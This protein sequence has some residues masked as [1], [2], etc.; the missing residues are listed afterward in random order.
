MAVHIEESGLE[1][2]LTLQ[3]DH[4]CYQMKVDENGYL[5]HLYYGPPV[6]GQDMS[7]R[8]RR[9][10]RSFSPNPPGVGAAQDLSLDWLPQEYPGSGTGDF[11][12]TALQAEVP[13]YTGC[14]LRFARMK[15]E[16]GMFSLSGLP[17]VYAHEDEAETLR[18]WLEDEAGGLSVCLLYG[19]LPEYDIITRAVEVT[20]IGEETAVLCKVMSLS[21]DLPPAP[22]DM[23]MFRGTH[24]DERLPER[25]SLPY[26]LTQT[27][28]R[29]GFSSHQA[30]PAVILCGPDTTETAGWCLG[31]AFVYSGSFLASAERSQ[32]TDVR[33]IMGIHPEDFSWVLEPGGTFTAPEVML[34]FSAQGFAPLSD[35]FQRAIRR[36]VCRGKWRDVTRPV[37][38]NNWEGTYFQFTGRKLMEIAAQAASL[39]AELF[40]LDDGWFGKRE[41]DTS[42]L[43]DWFPNERK[44]GM[45]LAELSSR[46]N[47]LGLKFGLWFEPEMVS[48]DSDLYR[49]HPDWALTVPDRDPATGRNQLVLD[50]SR[51]EVRDHL[52]ARITEVLD[53]ASIAYV[54]WDANRHLTDVFSQAPGVRSQGEVRHRC[55]LG[56]YE[57]LERLIRRYPDILW[58]GCSGGGGRFDAGMLYYHPQIWT[59]DNTDAVAR[60]GIQ[61]GTS[62]FY[63]A[64]AMGAHVSAVP[65][66]QTGRVTPFETRAAVAMSGAFGY[67]LDPAKLS[68]E[69]REM[70][71]RQIRDYRTYSYLF[72]KGYYRRLTGIGDPY[73]YTAWMHV[74]KDG[75]EAIVTAVCPL[76]RAQ[77]PFECLCLSGLDADASYTVK[78]LR[79]SDPEAKA[80]YDRLGP[81]TGAALMRAGLP[82]PVIHHDAGSV[83]VLLQSTKADF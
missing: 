81:L 7:Y 74:S 80:F 18:I 11:R 62:F 47:A 65:N 56:L 40:V 26:G 17:A 59:S 14:D 68:P 54:K 20:N 70:V 58:E 52:Y 61:Y 9:Y 51:R 42:S 19:V 21:L 24:A 60:L 75:S 2:I 39:G 30:N 44:L 13:G 73:R 22:T 82:L 23:V 36:H 28:S 79:S 67:E 37:L 48:P 43:G 63:P 31:A 6:G 29:R 15:Q 46:V 69:E 1:T 83:Q 10:N 45:S 78:L 57:L 4:T 27:E 66:H 50:L 71:R 33:L 64:S 32:F 35:R 5:L 72:Q 38:L 3:T 77:S 53:H 41:D 12:Q 8:L 16:R 76:S 34:S 49:A 25:V 55:I